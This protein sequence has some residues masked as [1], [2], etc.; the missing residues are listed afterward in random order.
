MFEPTGGDEQASELVVSA[1]VDEMV[2]AI[3]AHTTLSARMAE[4]LGIT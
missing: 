3:L 4:R 2:H 1:P